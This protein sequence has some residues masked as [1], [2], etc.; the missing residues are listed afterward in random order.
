MG[1]YGLNASA[2]DLPFHLIQLSAGFQIP[3]H[4]SVADTRTL[5]LT[6]AGSAV[7]RA[8]TTSKVFALQIVTGMVKLNMVLN[9]SST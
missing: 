9:R 1:L 3:L 5:H 8:S 7:Y 2:R 6:P 4:A